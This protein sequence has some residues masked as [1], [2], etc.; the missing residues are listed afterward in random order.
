MIL[1]CLS[2]DEAA[3]YN[4]TVQNKNK[5]TEADIKFKE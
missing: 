4:L 2:Q 1:V 5:I 3:T